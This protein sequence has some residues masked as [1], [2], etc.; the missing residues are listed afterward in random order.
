M[1]LG[2]RGQW[3]WRD[4]DELNGGVIVVFFS[5]AQQSKCLDRALHIG[6]YLNCEND[7][8]FQQVISRQ[9]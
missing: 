2:G 3:G 9:L 7:N 4:D 8:V 6:T 5:G 1:R